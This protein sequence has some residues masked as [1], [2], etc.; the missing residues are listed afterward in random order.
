MV[1]TFQTAIVIAADIYF[2]EKLRDD[3]IIDI[4]DEDSVKR[5]CGYCRKIQSD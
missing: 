5:N 3:F 2:E 4:T 1:L